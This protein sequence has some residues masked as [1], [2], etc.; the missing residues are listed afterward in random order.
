MIMKRIFTVALALASASA[1]LCFAQVNRSFDVEDLAD[2]VFEET[3]PKVR[4]NQSISLGFFPSLE[5]GWE[6]AL[7]GKTSI[8][9]RAGIPDHMEWDHT[10]E[11]WVG[12]F[13]IAYGLT[14]EPRVYLD[15]ESR[16]LRGRS[17]YMNTGLFASLVTE[18][19]ISEW[20]WTDMRCVPVLG[21]RKVTEGGMLLE[22]TAGMGV[23]MKGL[24][25]YFYGT[26]K[27]HLRLGY[28]F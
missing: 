15:L 28:C 22:F 13:E 24:G 2:M 6:E 4:S 9:L 26:P 5:Y 8:I 7:G 18:F 16:S 17:T 25:D 1:S 12:G 20:E 23:G 11:G 3:A 10:E 14:I 19:S 21:F 27:L